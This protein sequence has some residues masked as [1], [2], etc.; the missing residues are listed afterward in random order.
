M[1]IEEVTGKLVPQIFIQMGKIALLN[2]SVQ[3]TL[4]TLL[5]VV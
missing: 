4:V 1:F 2:S 5:V 3:N